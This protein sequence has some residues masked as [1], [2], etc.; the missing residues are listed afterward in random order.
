MY[1]SRAAHTVSSARYG[2][3]CGRE[4]HR[5]CVHRGQGVKNEAICNLICAAG[6]PPPGTGGRR[7]P[8]ESRGSQETR[9]QDA[10]P[11]RVPV[12]TLSAH[13]SREACVDVTP[14]AQWP[15]GVLRSE[16]SPISTD[17]S[18]ETSVSGLVTDPVARSRPDGEQT[19]QNVSRETCVNSTPFRHARS[20]SKSPR[21]ARDSIPTPGCGANRALRP[22]FSARS[23]PCSGPRCPHATTG[24]GQKGELRILGRRQ[25]RR[26]E[27][28]PEP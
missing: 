12:R 11:A 7:A 22:T 1:S 10:M 28:Y 20:P 23:T 21:R 5:I 14:L 15:R 27:C 8:P 6:L 25:R 24:A 18:R 19:P 17:V 2:A 26:W 16:R 4:H 3:E 13:I 9:E